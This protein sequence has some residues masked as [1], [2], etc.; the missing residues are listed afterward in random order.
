MK[1]KSLKI[2]LNLFLVATLL[3]A[4]NHSESND[5]LALESVDINS[6]FEAIEII[7]DRILFTI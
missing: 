6:N 1:R 7:I 5:K 4:C 3:V 2:V